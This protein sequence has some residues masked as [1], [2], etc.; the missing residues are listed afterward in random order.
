MTLIEAIGKIESGKHSIFC[1]SSSQN[2][3]ICCS[4]QSFRQ[5]VF[6]D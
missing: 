1:S 5:K 2:G 4:H 3:W 6:E